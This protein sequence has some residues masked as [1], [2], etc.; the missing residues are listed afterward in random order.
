MTKVKKYQK[1]GPPLR[2]K[3]DATRVEKPAI[4]T[5]PATKYKY[6][7][8]YLPI[9]KTPSSLDSSLYRYGYKKGVS[10]KGAGLFDDL[11]VHAGAQEGK[12]NYKKNSI[13]KQKTGGK[14]TKAK[15]GKWIQKATAS[16]KK[17]GTEGKCTPIT[18]KGCSGKAKTLAL[19]FKKIAAK[20]KGKLLWQRLQKLE[21]IRT[22]DLLLEL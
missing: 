22:Q 18:K 1:S 5:R 19:T 20:R 6:V 13:K 15:E 21:S 9:G 3:S 4:N 17:R 7:D 16:I 14:V 10:G 11:Q 8:R 12:E 2:A